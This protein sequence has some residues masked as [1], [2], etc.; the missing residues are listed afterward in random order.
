MAKEPTAL[1]RQRA[2]KSDHER[3]VRIT[4]KVNRRHGADLKSQNSTTKANPES[5]D[6]YHLGEGEE[7]N[8]LTVSPLREL[9]SQSFR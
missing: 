2:R 7:D 3:K 5:D 6:P 9:W 8:L 1:E 4:A